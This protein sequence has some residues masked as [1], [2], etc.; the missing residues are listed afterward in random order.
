MKK[1]QR[2]DD[3]SKLKEETKN[4]KI[5]KK[6]GASYKEI[7]ERLRAKN[8]KKYGKGKRIV[9]NNFGNYKL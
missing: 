9:L 5:S 1:V 8:I 2:C 4:I 7:V 6:F 3:K